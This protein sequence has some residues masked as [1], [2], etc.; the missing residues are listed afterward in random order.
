[1]F[2]EVSWIFK[3]ILIFTLGGCALMEPPK[4]QSSTKSIHEKVFPAEYENVWRA[5]QLSVQ[6]YPIRLNDI[7]R[8][9]LET[10]T[11][12]GDRYY[13]PP[14]LPPQ[15]TSGKQY[16]I[17]FRV[18]KGKIEG[19]PATKVVV[20]KRIERRRDFFST[21]EEKQSDGLEEATLLYRIGREL[22]IERALAKAR[23]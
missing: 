9:V 15:N 14:H 19:R 6:R 16:N 4:P 12:K 23:K 3:L 11:I 5:L 10:D 2:Q 21:A 8:G 18:L 13:V 20:L 17:L 1:M 7:D 22:D